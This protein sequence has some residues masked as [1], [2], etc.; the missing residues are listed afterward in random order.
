MIYNFESE[1]EVLFDFDYIDV[2]K[3]ICDTVMDYFACP[4]DSE[5]SLLLV[6]NDQIKEINSQTRGID[7]PTDV[8]SFPNVE[9][10][11]PGDLSD[12]DETGDYFEPDT[13]EFIL[14]DIVLSQDRVISQAEE[15]GHSVLREY[16]FLITHSMLHLFGFDHMEEEERIIM[17]EKQKDIMSILGILR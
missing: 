17:E 1:V 16:A 8:L 10:D 13:G 6:D 3:K 15:Y 11:T 7:A 4:Y 14:G 9:Y 12:L 2:Y 5:I